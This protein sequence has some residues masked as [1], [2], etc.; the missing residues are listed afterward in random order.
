M[1]TI[2]KSKGKI[3]DLIITYEDCIKV[4]NKLRFNNQ[5]GLFALE[6]NNGL[7]AIIGDIYQTFDKKDLYKSIEEKDVLLLDEP[8][9]F[10][11]AKHVE[12]L[13]KFLVNYKQPFIVISHDVSFLNSVC[14]V[15]YNLENKILLLA[16]SL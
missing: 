8:T 6:R 13:S 5:S 10:L 11:D 3:D 15:I 7:E 16:S 14:N 2:K 9:N 12:W 4:I 1:A